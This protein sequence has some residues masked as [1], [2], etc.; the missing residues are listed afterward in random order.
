M[1]LGPCLQNVET[2]GRV[3]DVFVTILRCAEVRRQQM[4]EQISDAARVFTPKQNQ[5]LEL[6]AQGYSTRGIADRL[7]ISRNTLKSHIKSIYDRAGAH[8]RDEAVESYRR[9]VTPLG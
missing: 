1:V 3:W 5:I 2:V 9:E 8:N 4:S 6:M 7:G